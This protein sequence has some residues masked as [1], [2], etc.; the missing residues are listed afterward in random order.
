V[1]NTFGRE[2]VKNVSVK[3]L[4]EVE[5]NFDLTATNNYQQNL[6]EEVRKKM[7]GI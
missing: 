1:I 3:K 6:L 7:G 2:R 4:R 5:K